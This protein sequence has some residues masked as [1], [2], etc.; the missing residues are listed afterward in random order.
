MPLNQTDKIVTRKAGERRSEA[1]L[2]EEELRLRRV[3]E[4]D[5]LLSAFEQQLSAP[6]ATNAAAGT[7][8]PAN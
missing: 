2:E 3:K 8:K 1:K 7:T 4:S 6:A 5:V